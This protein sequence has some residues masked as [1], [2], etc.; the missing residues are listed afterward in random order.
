M[1]LPSPTMQI[2]L[3]CGQR[4]AQAI[5][6]GVPYPIAPESGAINRC[7]YTKGKCR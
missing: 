2:T 4:S 6:A 1:K 5:A 7:G 3:R